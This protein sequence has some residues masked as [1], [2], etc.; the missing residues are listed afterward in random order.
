MAGLGESCTYVAAVLFYIEYAISLQE[1]KTV[2][3]EKAYWMTPNVREVGYKELKYI[4][5]TL[6]RSLKRKADEVLQ[7]SSKPVHCGSS[8]TH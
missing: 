3:K 8:I 5:F 1:N 2:T 4:D 6:P 7:S